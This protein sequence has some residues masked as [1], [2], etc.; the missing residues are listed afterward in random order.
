METMESSKRS[1]L[2]DLHRRAY[3][4]ATPEELVRQ[5]LLEKMI[6]QLGY[7]KELL[8]IEKSLSKISIFAKCKIPKRRIDV[9]CFTVVDSVLY[10][11]ILIECKKDQSLAQKAFNQVLAYNTYVKAPFLAV[12][13]PG[14]ELFGY[15]GAQFYIENQLPS[16]RE[17]MGDRFRNAHK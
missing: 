14:G 4:V 17:L 15:Y 6:T 9:V 5:A 13:F 7:P 8:C 2:Y 1:N 16:Y 3:F 10:P 11:L 12:S